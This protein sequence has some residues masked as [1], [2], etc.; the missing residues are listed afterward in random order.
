V[1]SETPAL[2]CC[3][4]LTLV[5]CCL[6]AAG[7]FTTPAYAHEIIGWGEQAF[8][9]SDFPI[10]NAPDLAALAQNRLIDCTANP[11]EPGC[12]PKAF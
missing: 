12:V 6:G 1:K 11:S 8:D 2:K 10:T 9:S 7:I 5:L 4:V 3:A